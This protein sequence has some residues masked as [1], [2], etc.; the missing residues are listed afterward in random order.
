MLHNFREQKDVEEH[1]DRNRVLSEDETN[2]ICKNN[3]FNFTWLTN[4]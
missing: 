1:I 2:F 4:L 3:V